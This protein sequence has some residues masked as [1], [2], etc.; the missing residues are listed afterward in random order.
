MVNKMSLLKLNLKQILKRKTNLVVVLIVA[1]I[2]SFFFVSGVIRLDME[3]NEQNSSYKSEIT[4]LKKDID[5]L[6]HMLKTSADQDEIDMLDSDLVT[7]K[8]KMQLLKERKAAFESQDWKRYYSCQE[9]L[10]EILIKASKYDSNKYFYDDQLNEALSMNQAYFQY[11]Q[12]NDPTL[13]S[14]FASAQGI[15]FFVTSLDKYLFVLVLCILVFIGSKLFGSKIKNGFDIDALVPITSFKHYLCSIMPMVICGIVIFISLFI[16][17]CIISLFTYGIGS[18]SSPVAIFDLKGFLSY[19]PFSSVV[20]EFVC[21]GLLGILF[22]VNI[23]YLIIR[24]CKK[25]TNGF[26]V[27]LMVLIVPTVLIT[28][29][30]PLYGIAQYIPF[31]YLNVVKVVTKEM[32]FLLN[33]AMINTFNGILVLSLSNILLIVYLIMNKRNRI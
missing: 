10:N 27:S 26:I 6:S 19:V 12:I 3:V 11:K 25:N 5:T 2:L 16:F 31:T 21:L 14:R 29:L 33:N 9:K 18:F 30:V 20:F 32:S 4:T 17:V 7:A 13:D 8:E 22:V 28:Q 15:S 23:S 24:I 1:T